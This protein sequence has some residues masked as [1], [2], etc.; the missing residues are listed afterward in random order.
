MSAIATRP[1][2]EP[3]AAPSASTSPAP[4]LLA[5]DG[6]PDSDLAARAAVDIAT[7]LRVPLHVVHCWLPATTAFGPAGEPTIDIGVVY[8]EPAQEVLRKQVRALQHQ[9]IQVAGEHLLMGRPTDE[10]P[11]VAASIGAQMIVIGSR[12][13]GAF[14][15]VVLGSVSDGV[16]HASSVPV[17]VIRG[18]LHAWP[19]DSIFVGVD[20]SVQSRQVAHAAA[21]IARAGGAALTV[22]TV[23]TAEWMDAATPTEA[24]ARTAARSASTAM[25]RELADQLTTTYAIPVKVEVLT[26]DPAEALLRAGTEE[27]TPAL[28]AVGSRG[29]GSVGRLTLGSVS[30]RLLHGAEG[31][32]LVSSLAR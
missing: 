22:A 11:G 4:I 6:S 31:P 28:L 30:T 25:V 18:G 9:G 7:G 21:G 12:G 8:G 5:V 10:I 19:P 16:V 24:R 32:V 2:I 1:G 29:L 26:G 13:L 14:K 23:I 3:T 17:L 15:R 20:G 27:S